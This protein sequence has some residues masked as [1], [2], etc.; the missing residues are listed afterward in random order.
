MKRLVNASEIFVL[1]MI[2]KKNDIYFESFEGCGDI[3]KFDL[4]WNY[5]TGVVLNGNSLR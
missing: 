2:K 3:L 5:D 1:L 4:Y